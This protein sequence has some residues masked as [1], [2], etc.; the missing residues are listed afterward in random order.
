MKTLIE[1]CPCEED[2][3]C[4]GCLHDFRCSDYNIVLD[5]QAAKIIISRLMEQRRASATTTTTTTHTAGEVM[6]MMMMMMMM[7]GHSFLLI[8]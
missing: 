5:K 3:G 6:M 8:C 7:M 4:P 1:G 2:V